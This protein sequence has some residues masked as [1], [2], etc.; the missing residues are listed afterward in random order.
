MTKILAVGDMHLKQEIILPRVELLAAR[1]EVDR[2]VL[3]GD[4]CDEWRA[5]DDLCMRALYFLA[6]WVDELRDSGLT[7]D[8]LLGNH[9]YQYLLEEAGPG[10]HV[11]LM[12]EVRNLLL[13]LEPVIAV[14][15]DGYLFTHAGLTNS[16]A[17]RYLDEPR[18]AFEACVQLNDMY[19]SSQSENH[20][21]LF[22]CGPGRGGWDTPSPLWADC[23]E[24]REDPFGGINQIVGHTPLSTCESS[25]EGSIV[26]DAD[27][28]L[29]FCD[30]FSLNGSMRPL[31]DGSMLLVND[32]RVSVVGGDGDCEME[33]WEDEVA[34]W[35]RR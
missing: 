31:G 13:D 34:S 33:P 1:Y 5:N 27:E 9:D 17:E 11:G 18:N 19:Q 35:L 29:W 4:Y 22:T 15:E 25:N 6:D 10:T 3:L 23:E 21:A 32:G 12:R 24:L 26:V 30:T 14:E 28:Q 16:W 7:I 20:C 8:I 2:I